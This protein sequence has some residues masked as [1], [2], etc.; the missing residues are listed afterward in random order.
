MQYQARSFTS[1]P[2]DVPLDDEA[3]FERDPADRQFAN[4][5]ERGLRVLQCFNANAQE[6][7]NSE[8]AARTGL[9]KPTVSRLTHTLV[10][11]GYLR[12][13]PERGRFGL[14]MAVLSLGY[15]LLAGLQL[16]RVAMP[17]MTELADRINGTVAIAVRD[18]MQIVTL[19]TISTN[20]VL[21]RKPGVGMALPFVGSTPGMAW[22]IGATPKERASAVREILHQ[23]PRDW[24]RYRPEFEHL[25]RLYLRQGLVCRRNVVR[26]DTTC[27]ALPLRSRAGSELLVLSCVFSTTRDTVDSLESRASQGLLTAARVIGNQLLSR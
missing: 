25:Q 19:E 10:Q 14:G 27:V 15:P 11:L 1:Q 2:Y 16:R 24:E 13:H 18:H 7:G 6:L 17:P 5:L 22:L 12:R 8:L 9:P 20:D 21:R 3:P 26:P 4:T 23:K